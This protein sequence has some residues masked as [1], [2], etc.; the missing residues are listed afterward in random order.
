M[1]FSLHRYFAPKS[2]AKFSAMR[3]H[4]FVWAKLSR[5]SNVTPSQKQRKT[6]PPFRASLKKAGWQH[7]PQPESA[8]KEG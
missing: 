3:I 6:K 5:I 7:D 1:V 8:F 4:F 2:V